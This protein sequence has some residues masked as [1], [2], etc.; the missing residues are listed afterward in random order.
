MDTP[1]AKCAWR[2]SAGS[3][4][5]V[6]SFSVAGLVLSALSLWAAHAAASPALDILYVNRCATGCMLKPG[7]DDAINR[8][9][10]LIS[11]NVALPPFTF[12]DAAFNATV[13]CVRA[14]LAPY[15]VTVVTTDPGSVARREVILSGSSTAIGLPSLVP[16]DAPWLYGTP[17]DNVIAFA[18]AETIGNDVDR[19][20]WYT[21]QD[22]GTLYGLDFEYYCPDLMATLDGCGLKA[23]TNADAPCGTVTARSCNV[24]PPPAPA[25]QN[26]AARLS[27]VPGAVEVIFRGLFDIG[28][29]P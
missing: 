13:S 8:R 25:Q 22:F 16:N 14:V 19:L 3:T 12:G 9:S 11:H 4:M 1:A 17:I 7:A 24:T 18:F 20:C 29:S 28:P 6:G 2:R 21:A 23:F 5:S 15:D 27:V 26:S 10:S